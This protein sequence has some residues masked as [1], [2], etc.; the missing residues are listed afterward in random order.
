VQNVKDRKIMTFST[1]LGAF[2][3]FADEQV[4]MRFQKRTAQYA[5]IFCCVNAH[6]GHVFYDWWWDTVPHTDR[7][8]RIWSEPWQPKTGP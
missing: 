5:S 8:G 6:P 7:F 2:G 1:M 3:G 4:G